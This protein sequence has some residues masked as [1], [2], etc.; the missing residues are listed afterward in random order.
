MTKVK[1]RVESK[2]TN[3]GTKKVFKLGQIKDF[4]VS[5]EMGDLQEKKDEEGN[6]I[7]LIPGFHQQNFK[8]GKD[9]FAEIEIPFEVT[10][11]YIQ[12]KHHLSRK[13][14]RP[15]EGSNL[16][17]IMIYLE[18]TYFINPKHIERN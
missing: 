12:A 4:W 15:P 17:S 7:D 16:H 9:E 5:Y 14:V 11:I 13:I 18:R 2:V 6:I 8:V 1:V 10:H 3:K